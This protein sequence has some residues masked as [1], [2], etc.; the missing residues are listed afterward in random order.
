MIEQ[1]PDYTDARRT[2][3]RWAHILKR[4]IAIETAREYGRT[5]YRVWMIPVR[6]SDRTGAQLWMEVIHP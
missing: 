2:A 6:A 1:T 5:V 3:H 4:P